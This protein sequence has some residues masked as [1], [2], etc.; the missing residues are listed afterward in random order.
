MSSKI[1]KSARGQSCT[2]RLDGCYGGPDNE[3]V[4]FA[5]L[6]NGAMG[7]KAMDIHGAYCCASCHDV[8]DGR[9]P[10]EYDKE[11]LLLSHLMGMKRTQEILVGKGLM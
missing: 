2:V 1:T 6:C 7:M 11:Y 5:H 9:K 10:S 3:T 4:V 8:L